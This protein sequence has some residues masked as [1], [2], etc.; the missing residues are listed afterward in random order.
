M[1]I[2]IIDQFK[3]NAPKPIDGRFQIATFSDVATIDKTNWYKGMI[4]HI[5]D[6]GFNFYID[7]SNDLR[8]LGIQRVF[9]SF[10]SIDYLLNNGIKKGSLVVDEETK[11]NCVIVIKDGLYILEPIALK[12]DIEALPTHFYN[13]DSYS[14]YENAD[15][16]NWLQPTLCCINDGIADGY[17]LYDE[18]QIATVD[19]IP[20]TVI[21]Q[22]ACVTENATGFRLASELPENHGPIGQNALDL[23]I[24][25]A[26]STTRG[27]TGLES[28]ALGRNT[29]A[30]GNF[31]TAS[32]YGSRALG[33]ASIALGS[34]TV[35]ESYGSF[36]GGYSTRSGGFASLAIGSNTIALNIMTFASGDV[37]TAGRSIVSGE[38][39]FSHQ[40][41]TGAIQKDIAGSCSAVLGGRNNRTTVGGID[42]VI[43]GGSENTAMHERTV[44]LGCAN[45][46]SFENGWTLVENLKSFGSV[47]GN[48]L[49]IAAN[50]GFYGATP[51]TKQ[52]VQYLRIDNPLAF[53][54]YT[55]NDK[56]LA[57]VA[58]L[59]L[60]RTEVEELRKTNEALL[61]AL[62]TYG[63]I[64]TNF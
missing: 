33:V 4:V 34:N 49:K 20:P 36:A 46:T 17:L 57:Y 42:S 54:G 45:R 11:T 44:I 7:S 40:K 30:S 61:T 63:L 15:K 12:L 22:L 58:D 43:L 38:V 51:Q 62:K 1:A 2:E 29:T 31:T 14:D 6:T 50:I 25:D 28:V 13:F 10:Q 64:S 32:G 5:V 37:A 53:E 8:L 41:V 55:V 23:S 9:P 48:F 35:A 21:S 52:D 3:V 18:K 16:T 26:P 56:M 27:A 24:S 47:E 60:L 39:A 59:N 19:M